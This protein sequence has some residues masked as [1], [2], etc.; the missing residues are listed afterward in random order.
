MTLGSC[1]FYSV[2][3]E[4]DRRLRRA[5]VDRGLGR[6][7]FEGRRCWDYV[8]RL[9]WRRGDGIADFHPMASS[10][11]EKVEGGEVGGGGLHGE[12]YLMGACG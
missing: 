1:R 5:W 9:L 3:V 6:M 12:L 11:G 7:G 8:G 10:R 2:R 4:S